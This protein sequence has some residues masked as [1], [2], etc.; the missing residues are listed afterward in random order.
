M[1]GLRCRAGPGRP[2]AALRPPEHGGPHARTQPGARPGRS[3]A[4]T[5][6]HPDAGQDAPPGAGPLLPFS[7]SDKSSAAELVQRMGE[8]AFQARNVGL[9]AQIWEAML[10]D[11]TTIFF[12]LAGAMVPAGMRPLIVY[13]IENRLIDVIVSTG[14]NLYRD[15]YESLGFL[16]S[17]GDPQGDDVRLAHLRVVRF[18]DVLAPEH[19]F[20]RAERF[21]T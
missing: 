1:Q 15:V 12:G 2:Q 5:D 3:S 7:V 14:A 6:N 19:E 18:Y 9:A 20:S 16:H 17:Q 21:C 4:M 11:E 8:T 10:H 13:L